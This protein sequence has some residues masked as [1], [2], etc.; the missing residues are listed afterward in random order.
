MY[1]T[2][3]IYDRL[4]SDDMHY[5]EYFNRIIYRRAC[6]SK[7]PITEWAFLVLEPCKNI[8]ISVIEIKFLLIIVI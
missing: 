2:A 8:V 7:F 5:L 3:A 6:I 1:D 4:H